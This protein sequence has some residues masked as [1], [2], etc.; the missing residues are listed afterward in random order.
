[1][2]KSNEILNR[3]W[4]YGSFRPMQ[5]DIVDAAIYGKDVLA[6]LPTGGGKSIC[7]QVPGLARDGIC[8]VISPLIAL[9]E[10]QVQQLQ[11]R[12]IK[13]KALTSGMSF[14]EIDITLDNAKFGGIEFLYVSPERIQ[15]RLFQERVKQ[16]NVGL[17]V[18][19]EAHCISEW[20]HDFRPSYK[21]I[22]LLRQLHPEV[23]MMAVTATATKE[24]VDDIITSLSLKNVQFFEAPFERSNISYEVYPVSN[25]LNAIT[26]L[27]KRNDGNVGIIYCQTR[28]SVKNVLQHLLSHGIKANMYHGGLNS[29][30]RSL[31]L[32][33]WM[34][35]VTPIMV[36]TNAFG[37]GIDKPN[38][39]FVTHYELPNNPEAYFQEAGRAGRDGNESRT[40]AFVGSNDIAELK[41]RIIT[42]FP[43]IETVKLVYRAMCNY[44]KIAIGSGKDESYT[45]DFSE[46][47]KRFQLK[48]DVIY[49]ALKLLEMNGDIA[50]TA[51]GLRGSR[52][53]FTID[54]AH[55]Y[56]FQ[57]KNARVDPLITTLS[58]MYQDLFEDFS[59]I[60]ETTVCKRLKINQQ[61][62]ESQLKFLEER[63]II[64][65]T[66][67]TSLPLV[68]FLHERLPDDY[69]SFQPEVYTFR[70]EK[71]LERVEA[72][73]KYVESRQCRQQFIIEYFGQT[74]N[75]C[76]KCDICKE[77]VLFSKHPR[78]EMEILDVVQT[79]KTMEEILL[80]FEEELTLKIKNLI[81]ELLVAERISFSENKYSLPK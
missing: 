36:A 30:Q 23:P 50:L 80:S 9:M 22:S 44:L 15:T 42:Q 68:T 31:A 79:P 53:K 14:R 41:E 2:Q 52:I 21:Q 19:D 16:M 33:N 81:R 37:M 59:E 60:D 76:G 34:S 26:R 8:I 46:F 12:G 11:Q 57:L 13:A 74:S 65:I 77:N 55:L 67:R 24:V 6:L 63:G 47:T 35:E 45:I 75:P 48:I 38:V 4:G 78:L 43:P 32:N 39:R 10:D 70:K 58:R 71:A 61:E 18:V 1:M 25:K 62:L 72:M 27:C 54:N 56:A 64:D 40:F 17:F 51:D 29:Q 3:V 73:R 7:F 49:P 20:G 28:K 66:W 5:E 69:I